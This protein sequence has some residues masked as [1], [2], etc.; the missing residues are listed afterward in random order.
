MEVC[1]CIRKINQNIFY[2]SE[3]ICRLETMSGERE[4]ESVS[5]CVSECVTQTQKNT[6]THGHTFV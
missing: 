4:R 6:T 1:K 3:E 5:V 2:V